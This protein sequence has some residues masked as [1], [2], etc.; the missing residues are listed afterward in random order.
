MK[1]LLLLLFFGLA[2]AAMAQT[3]PPAPW[4]APALMQERVAPVFLR[5]WRRAE[6]RASCALL[7]PVDLGAGKGAKPRRANFYGGWAVA[8][9]R[10]GSPGTLPSGADCVKCGR[11]VFGIAGTGSTVGN[12]NFANFSERIVW[13]DGSYAGYD[14]GSS[15][16]LAY[17][18]V[19][20]QGCLYNVWSNLGSTHL[21]EL[22]GKLR[23]VAEAR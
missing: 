7:A 2:P 20:G 13:A 9:D 14:A 1:R 4:S 11:S 23:F 19:Q 16:T 10:P 17:L 22:L 15:R 18:K 21:R 6:N 8:Y 5:E 12:D 3:A